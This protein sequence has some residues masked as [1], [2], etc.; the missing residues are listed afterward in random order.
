M[1]LVIKI[2]IMIIKII[3]ENHNIIIVLNINKFID[4]L[5]DDLREFTGFKKY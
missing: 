5:E 3:I 4:R 1:I 2:N